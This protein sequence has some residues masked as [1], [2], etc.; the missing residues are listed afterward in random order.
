MIRILLGLLVLSLLACS[1]HEQKITTDEFVL[2]E[3]YTIELLAAE[4][5]LDSPVAMTFDLSLIHI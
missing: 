2:Q 5:L 1:E 3:G 4:P